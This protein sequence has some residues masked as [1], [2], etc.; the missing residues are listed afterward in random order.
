MARPSERMWKAWNHKKHAGNR[1][2]KHQFLHRFTKGFQTLA[3]TAVSFAVGRWIRSN[4]SSPVFDFCNSMN[5][6]LLRRASRSLRS[7]SSVLFWGS[8]L[9]P[10]IPGGG[11]RGGRWRGGTP[12]P[13]GIPMRPM[14]PL[15]PPLGPSIEPGPPAPGKMGGKPERWGSTGPSHISGCG[16]LGI[17]APVEAS[18]P[19]M[20]PEWFGMLPS[21]GAGS[22][23]GWFSWAV[24][25]N[26]LRRRLRSIPMT[27]SLAFPLTTNSSKSTP[28]LASAMHRNALSTADIAPSSPP[29]SFRASFSAGE[30]EDWSPSSF[31]RTAAES[32][33]VKGTLSRRQTATIVRTN[34]NRSPAPPSP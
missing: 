5:D 15:G 29:S 20:P 10:P 23:V 3:A 21:A 1:T 33:A 34:A 11:A 12:I 6:F 24:S 19:G 27:I 17:R 13:L 28:P 8:R 9:G 25:G 2:E 18:T 7:S 26:S 4:S 22:D 14:T 16:G 31:L 32:I 30:A